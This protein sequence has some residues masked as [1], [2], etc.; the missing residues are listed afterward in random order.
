MIVTRY[1]FT[2]RVA[3]DKYLLINSLSG[4]VD[5]VDRKVV[6]AFSSIRR[7]A[8]PALPADTI[9]AL[10]HRGYLYAS[11][12]QEADVVDRAVGLNEQFR[13]H[14]QS[15]CFVLCPTISCNLRCPYCFEP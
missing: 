5:L 4:A 2:Y 9:E 3:D 11:Q 15:L 12:S 1:V 6:Q 8:V 10:S 7:G 13:A 14:D